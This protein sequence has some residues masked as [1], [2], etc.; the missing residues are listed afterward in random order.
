MNFG[1]DNQSGVSPQILQALVEACAGT[2]ASYGNDPWTR[3]A[4]GLLAG[5]FEHDVRAF[6]VATG[7]AANCLALSA[8]APP[9]GGIF[10]H[11]QAHLASDESS[12]PEFFTGGARLLPIAT[13]SGKLTPQALQQA[14]QQ[15]PDARP[16][17]IRPSALSL[18]QATENGLV[19]SPDE[20]RALTGIAHHHGLHVHMDGARFANA[21]AALG[22]TPAQLGA[23]AGID[24]LTFGASK[25]GALAAEA[26]VFFN[27]ALA[28]DFDLRRKRAGQ[29]VSK[30]RLFGAQF[31]GW[32]RDG[33][34]LQLAHHANA[35]A[36][37]LAD[38]LRAHAQIQ[39]AWPVQ[40]NE[41][42]VV[43]PRSLLD[44][45]HE[46]GVQ[47]Y[48]WYASSLPASLP[49]PAGH[50]PARFVTSWATRTE[51]IDALQAL[52]HRLR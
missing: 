12:A 27:T 20:L 37:A 22:C 39:L 50:V 17:G 29:L 11:A 30:G 42:F 35:C 36:T 45:L 24:V 9:W 18:T 31:C 28:E 38:V 23:Q 43:L 32:L 16:H 26:V 41:V 14:L 5:L 51:E 6:F 13:D 52:L 2:A 33:H 4:E 44:Q 46:A 34:W 19:Y 47:C 21:V 7:T 15:L 48:D 49:L 1:S 25:D 40:A 3:E 10:C 8:I